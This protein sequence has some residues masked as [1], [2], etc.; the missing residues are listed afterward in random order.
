MISR[1]LIV[2]AGIAGPTLAYWLL[3]AGI[4]PTLLESAPSLRTGGYMIDFWG[5]GYT[6]AERMGL[7]PRLLDVGYAIREMRV[8]DR[9]FRPRITFGTQALQ[10]ALGDRFV[11]VLRGDLA[12]LLYHSL[13]GEVETLFGN[14]VRSLVQHE[15]GVD[16]ELAYRE[17]RRFDLVIGADGVHS[18]V[19]NL[20]FG[21]GGALERDLGYRVAA[22]TAGKYPYRDDLVYVTRTIPGRQ[23]ARCALRD[24]RTVFFMIMSSE[25]IARYDMSSV[26]HQKCALGDVLA[27]I[28]AERGAILHALD[29][30]EDFYFDVVSQAH[31]P[32]WSSGRI[33]LIGD[34]AYGPSFLAGEGASLAM[35]GAYMLAGELATA[36]NA[37]AA[38]VNYEHRLRS[39]AERKQRLALRMGSWFVPHS[40]LGVWVRNRITELASIPLLSKLFLRSL[41]R[42]DL[43]LRQQVPQW[44]ARA[45]A[46]RVST[47]LGRVRTI[48]S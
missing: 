47:A 34:A 9:H 28:G 16:V 44:T 45:A 14:E 41:V 7:L 38:F 31:V 42:D 29:S 12:Q 30:S 5:P 20:M 11:S 4:T 6:V 1:V 35:T 15:G 43:S 3:R 26:T 24:D 48:G 18:G 17:T 22:F 33:A 27:D 39:Y 19:R 46:R 13:N 8:V 40:W 23:V 2:G 37:G 25:L 32:R 21:A 36:A 10:R